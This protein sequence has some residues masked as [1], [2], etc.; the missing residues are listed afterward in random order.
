MTEPVAVAVLAKA[1]LAGF[2]KTRLIPQLGA[3]GAAALQARLIERAAATAGDAAIGPVTLWATP[4]AGHPVF[5]AIRARAGIALACQCDGDLGARML[6]AAAAANGPVLVIGTDCPLLTSAHLRGAA[7]ILRNGTDVVVYP[8][9]DGGYV[10]IGM[11]RPQP[12]LLD[13]MHWST[14]GVMEETRR[15]L[16]QHGLRWEEPVTLWDVDL[17][18]DLARL[19]E[20][21][22]EI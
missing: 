9:E 1:P 4:D 11:R 3:D 14:P 18:H 20:L 19:R 10:L 17:P 16:R 6:A 13:H 8:A 22:W 21:G 7:D 5:Q 2:A 15:R 12:A